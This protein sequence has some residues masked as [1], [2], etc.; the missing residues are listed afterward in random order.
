MSYGWQATLRL[1][2]TAKAVRRSDARNG[3]HPQRRE[4]GPPTATSRIRTSGRL[5]EQGLARQTLPVAN[6]T[7]S[8]ALM[9]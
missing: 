2:A 8:D 7:T 5:D 9:R 4:G 1:A 3:L 6:A